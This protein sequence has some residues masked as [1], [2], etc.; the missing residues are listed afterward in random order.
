MFDIVVASTNH[1]RLCV[2]TEIQNGRHQKSVKYEN[3][4]LGAYCE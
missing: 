2:V 3:D 4:D 1:Y